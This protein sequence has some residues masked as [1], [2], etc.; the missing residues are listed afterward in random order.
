MKNI[1]S[2]Q[3]CMEGKRRSWFNVF[4]IHWNWIC[5]TFL[6]KVRIRVQ[7]RIRMYIRDIKRF[8][9]LSCIYIYIYIGI[10]CHLSTLSCL[11]IWYLFWL[12]LSVRFNTSDISLIDIPFWFWCS[13]YL[14]TWNAYRIFSNGWISVKINGEVNLL[15]QMLTAYFWWFFKI[16]SWKYCLCIHIRRSWLLWSDM[17]DFSQQ[18]K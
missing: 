12:L 6:K 7:I 4:D 9:L 8:L 11:L 16:I 2:V 13:P 5:Q 1:P 3:V 14:L 18:N 15:N 17:A 10:R